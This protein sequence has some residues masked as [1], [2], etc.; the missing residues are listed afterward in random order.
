MNLFEVLKNILTKE[1]MRHDDWTQEQREAFFDL[2]LLGMYVDGKLS[3]QEMDALD[4][5]VQTLMVETGV[6]WE[7]YISSALHKIRNVEGDEKQRYE[8]LQN[9]RG[10][11]GDATKRGIA[12]QEL[13]ELLAVD[14]KEEQE[15]S[16]LDDV[17]ALFKIRPFAGEEE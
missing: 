15:Q 3:V 5:N 6:S 8:L 17:K 16:F 9:I 11:L 4:Q 14:G 10:R 7:A 12:V 13:K 2:L 1:P